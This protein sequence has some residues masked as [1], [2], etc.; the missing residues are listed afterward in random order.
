MEGG[1]EISALDVCVCVCVCVR[2]CVC[3]CVNTR[4]PGTSPLLALH[5]ALNTTTERSM[6]TLMSTT[7]GAR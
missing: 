5:Y 2:V 3:V 7:R 1:R 6:G 4:T